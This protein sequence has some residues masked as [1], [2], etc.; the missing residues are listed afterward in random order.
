MTI[1]FESFTES[2][3]KDALKLACFWNQRSGFTKDNINEHVDNVFQHHKRDFLDREMTRI[4]DNSHAW[5][6]K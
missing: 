1:D 3:L 6:R 5:D 4:Y 2:E